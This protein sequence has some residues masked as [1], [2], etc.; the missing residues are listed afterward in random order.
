MTVSHFSAVQTLV[1][2][3]D[4]IFLHLALQFVQIVAVRQE[5]DGRVAQIGHRFPAPFVVLARL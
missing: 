2:V 1:K 5:F 4:A 3:E